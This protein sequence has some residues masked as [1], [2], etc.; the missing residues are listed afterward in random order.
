GGVAHGLAVDDY[1]LAVDHAERAGL[2]CGQHA[3]RIVAA[4]H[5]EALDGVDAG[6]EVA[7]E[8][9]DLARIERGPRRPGQRRGRGDA[10]HQAMKERSHRRSEGLLALVAADVRAPR[11]RADRRLGLPDDVELAVAAHFAD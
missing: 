7:R 5:P 1:D 8:A 6:L 11:L 4:G 10:E 3:A 2:Q 9:G